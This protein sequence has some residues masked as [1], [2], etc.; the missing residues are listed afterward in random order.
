MFDLTLLGNKPFIDLP[1]HLLGW[2]G[3]F[4]LAAGILWGLRKKF[5][6][7]DS[8]KFWIIFSIL[9]AASIVLPLLAGITLPIKTALPMPN[10][11]RESATPSIIL[12][13]AVPWILAAGM[14]GY[15][16]AVVMGFVSGL[17]TAFWNTH[18]LFTP[19]ETALLAF[20]V[21]FLLRQN[22]TMRFF[23]WMR[24]PLGAAGLLVF[25]NIPISLLIT[26]LNSYGSL[27][28]R[29]DYAFTQSWVFILVNGIQI[30]L[31]GCLLELFMVNRSRYWIQ[32]KSFVHSPFEIALQNKVMF[33]ALPIIFVL[34]LALAVADWLIAT[35]AAADMLE[36]RLKS[37]AEIASASLPSLIDTGQGLVLDIVEAGVP[38]DSAVSARD[39]LQ[40]KMRAM[41][42]FTSFQLVDPSGVTW[43]VYPESL[44]QVTVLTPQEQSGITLALSGIPIQSYVVSPPSQGNSAQITYLAAIIDETGQARGVLIARTDLDVNLVAQPAILSI[45]EIQ[46]AGGDG[47]ILDG[48][49]RIL[50]HENSQLLLSVYQGKVPS[51]SSYFEDTSGTGTRK[52]VYASISDKKDWKILLSLPSSV[53]QSLALRIAV[54]LLAISILISF[55]AYFLLRYLM[56]SLSAKLV[57]LANQADMIAQ[58]SLDEK[59]EIKGIDEVGRLGSAFEKMRLGLKSRLSELDDLLEVSKGIASNFEIG[60]TSTHLLKACMSYGADSA[61]LILKNGYSFGFDVPIVSYSAGTLAEEYAGLDRILLNQIGDEKLLVVPS[62]TR[63]Q[64]LSG[65]N[66]EPLPSAIVALSLTDDK[67]DYGILWIA[68]ADSHRFYDEEI[69][70]LNTIAGQSVLAISNSSLFMNAEVG[71]KRLESVLAST[72]EPVLVVGDTGRLLIANEAARKVEGLINDPSEG[73]PVTGEIASQDFLDFVAYSRESGRKSGEIQILGKTYEVSI[74][75]VTIEDTLVGTVSVLRDITASRELEKLKS[76]FV[77]TVS[78][79]LRAP[80]GI[81]RGY[82]TMLQMVGELN[83]QQKE[84]AGKI[85]SDLDIIDQMV[86]KLLDLGRIESGSVLQIEKVAPQDLFDEV[87]RVLQPLVAQR[88]VQVLADS[89]LAQAIEIDADKALLRQALINLLENAI[90][91]SPLSGKVRV[92]LQASLETVTFE[93]EDH[94]PGIAPLDIAKIFDRFSRSGIKE[95]GALKGSGLGLSIVKSIAERH[96]GRVWASSTLGKGSIFYLEVPINQSKK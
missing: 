4:G 47:V 61:R 17:I 48:E 65:I 91:F 21:S 67:N 55:G 30:L 13:A 29:L 73:S 80:M 3:W 20:L 69:N 51:T 44:T 74:S 11:T 68:Y 88:K 2:L 46:A 22:F 12:F 6:L 25:L 81:V 27:A 38:L 90:K 24:R 82:A 77:A 42:F 10:I 75:P 64:R 59:V 84:Y 14:L 15:W 28:A 52:M 79:D 63:V 16:P 32:F 70:F 39:F 60:N 18:N 87:M 34:L 93:I 62:K 9:L 31:A 56:G 86:E 33:T 26:F 36:G 49:N 40:S 7:A 96:G 89:S 78:H 8:R 57:R 95:G 50:Y 94:G 53:A 54:P 45:K 37:T 92:G 71:K 1:F 66:E 19:L 35:R 23:Q 85:I 76:D 72:P 41:P 83:D 5:Q 43:L 58:G